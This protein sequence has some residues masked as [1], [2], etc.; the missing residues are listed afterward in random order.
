MTA[1]Y[2]QLLLATLK[3]ISMSRIPLTL[4]CYYSIVGL[5]MYQQPQDFAS[6]GT[7][8]KS[9]ASVLS[10]SW[11]KQ[12]YHLISNYLTEFCFEEQHFNQN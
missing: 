5:F 2:L 6:T 1:I 9:K 3:Y 11:Y 4:P 7:A 8:V 12:C 10:P